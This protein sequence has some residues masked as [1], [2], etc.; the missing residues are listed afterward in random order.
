KLDLRSFPLYQEGQPAATLSLRGSAQGS[1]APERI[2]ITTG[3]S[4]ARFALAAAR[5]KRLQPLARPGDIV[6]LA[7]GEPLD[8]AQ[9]RKLPALTAT[10]E[11]PPSTRPRVVRLTV[12]A[13]RNV[14]VE[15]PDVH[16]ELGLEP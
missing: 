6:L 8:R 10:P 2:A 13:P 14:W 9:A 7:D 11:A 16:L 5:P 4:E 15:G 3:I 12:E 1:V